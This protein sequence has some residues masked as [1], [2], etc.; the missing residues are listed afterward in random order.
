VVALAG[1]ILAMPR[2]PRRLT[3]TVFILLWAAMSIGMY[4]QVDKRRYDLAATRIMREA[5]PGDRILVIPDYSYEVMKHYEKNLPPPLEEHDKPWQNAVH[6]LIISGNRLW[7]VSI[8][9]QISA[10]ER[11]IQ[12][13]TTRDLSLAINIGPY[14][15]LARYRGTRETSENKPHD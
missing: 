14:L 10:P 8:G 1:G 9:K 3:A 13:Y 15:R 12:S 6:E 11:F 2:W 7:V 4:R 5:Q